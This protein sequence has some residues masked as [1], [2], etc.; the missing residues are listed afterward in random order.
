MNTPSASLPSTPSRA[1]Q[2]PIPFTIDLPSPRW[3][4]VDAAA[5]GVTHT[6]FL[7]KR[8]GLGEDYV[9][10]I[11]VSGGWRTGVRSLEAV[12]DESLA[13]LRAEGAEEV[14]L[15]TRTVKDSPTAPGVTQTIGALATIEGRR[16]DLRQ[17]QVVL[18]YVDLGRPERMAVFIHTLSC[19]YKQAPT[20]VEEFR[21]YVRSIEV[22]P[23]EAAP[24]VP[25]AD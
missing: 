10:T 14:E 8:T 4:P 17:S 20:M 19:T 11:A 15:V 5:V 24:D 2:P 25:P 1:P 23:D 9:P 13:K 6:F 22:V 21:A 12:A 3:V 7:A 16:H 18:G